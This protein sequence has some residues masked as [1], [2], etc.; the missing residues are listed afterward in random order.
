MADEQSP[1]PQ[2]GPVRPDPYPSGLYASV[3][4]PA[5]P[6]AAG[7][8]PPTPPEP[9]DEPVIARIGD[10][11]VTASTVRTPVGDFAL[12]GSQWQVDDQRLTERK[13]PKWAIA[14]A[15]VGFLVA[16]VFSLLFL[17]AKETVQTGVLVVSVRNG[18]HR[19]D[20]RIQSTDPEQV[21]HVHSLVNYVRSL[22]SL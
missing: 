12:R 19:Y 7:L 2:S 9:V 11:Q 6:Y 5:G 8:S 20:A 1:R 3:P 16:P 13:T 18:P 21:Q 15:I 10:I 17:L 14:C 22:A 4:Y